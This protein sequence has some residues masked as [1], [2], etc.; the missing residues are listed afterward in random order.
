MAG[1]HV[2]MQLLLVLALI[3]EG[4]AVDTM[5]GA[6]GDLG[7]IE[8]VGNQAYTAEQLRA[9]LSEDLDLIVAGRPEAERE[10]W[11]T[12]LQ[13]QIR[14]GYE[15]C[16]YA[17][18]KVTIR[19]DEA[20]GVIIADIDEGPL[21]HCGKIE[22]EG[23][24]TLPIE[25]FQRELRISR[26]ERRRRGPN[27]P[28]VPPNLPPRILEMQSP[29]WKEGDVA[30]FSAEY[31]EL[32]MP[33]L[34]S[35]FQS[36]G[37]FSPRFTVSAHPEEDLT[38][39]LVITVAEEGP[40][41]TLDQCKVTGG[42][43]NSREDLL[44]YLDLQIGMPLNLRVKAEVERKLWYSARF[45]NYHVEIVPGRSDAGQPQTT[46]ELK[47][48]EC[49][50]VPALSANITTEQKAMLQFINW[51]G[52]SDE[53]T[54]DCEIRITDLQD[55]LP[56]N[57][58][59]QKGNERCEISAI[60]LISP[61]NN[62]LIFNGQVARSADH[63]LLDWAV[64]LTP[65]RMILDS[66]LQKLRYESTAI[67]ACLVLSVE[68]SENRFF[69]GPGYQT[70]RNA[71]E[72]PFHLRMTLPPVL[73]L[74]FMVQAQPNVRIDGNLVVVH[75]EDG[76]PFFSFDRESGALVEFDLRHPDG[77]SFFK[78]THQPG[79]YDKWLENQERKMSV[80]KRSFLP[81]DRP[82]S[83]FVEFAVELLPAWKE[84]QSSLPIHELTQLGRRFVQKDIFHGFDQALNKLL[85]S[86]AGSNRYRLPCPQQTQFVG[87]HPWWLNY[88][89]PVADA[90]LPR[91]DQF[92]T[93]QREFILSEAMRDYRPTTA[94]AGLF[95]RGEVGPVTF[96]AVSLARRYLG[97]PHSDFLKDVLRTQATWETFQ[98]DCEQWLSDGS[99]FGHLL[100]ATVA[101]LE[102]SNDD[103][104][105]SLFSIFNLKAADS[106]ALRQL[107]QQLPALRDKPPREALLVTLKGA[108]QDFIEPALSGSV[109]TKAK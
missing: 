71:T 48:K 6:L 51:L 88:V 74:Q 34:H 58:V 13:R 29:L 21:F 108:W 83:A 46:L 27:D 49:A 63:P 78:V 42:K 25:D 96:Q 65:D 75:S 54:N 14:S 79:L 77:H 40:R 17:K 81:G 66:A 3:P 53:W 5:V 68:W 26:L 69:I 19:I 104:I 109:N 4:L 10:L 7:R 55:L 67:G 56:L 16:G 33:S 59:N 31:W 98:L 99:P 12:V 95:S 24:K 36:F 73:V 15:F 9:G 44:K 23:A 85:K 80:I 89:P 28:P 101:A 11:L 87:S 94:F 61:R 8:F 57:P 37:Y 86:Q 84:L 43:K 100:F 32:V 97:S 39:T 1:R 91:T 20:R 50:D 22:I 2:A 41:A 92:H 52:S 72:P 103:E 18:A 47:L 38:A 64:H 45:L 60:V 76:L 35:I 30:L 82:I 90:F 93:I 62:A 102:E 105:M 106:K 107:L 70:R